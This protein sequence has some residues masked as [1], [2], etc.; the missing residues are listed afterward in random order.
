MKKT[1]FGKFTILWECF[2]G[3]RYYGKIPMD[4]WHYALRWGEAGKNCSNIQCTSKF[5]IFKGIVSRD[6]G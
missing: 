6:G 2:H 5:N 3:N 1:N 4:I